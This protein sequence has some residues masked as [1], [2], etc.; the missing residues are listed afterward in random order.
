MIKSIKAVKGADKFPCRWW[1]KV[2]ALKR[3]K[4]IFKPG[5]NVIIGPNGSGK[6]T[7]TK[8]LAKVFFVEQGGKTTFTQTAFMSMYN[9]V[10]GGGMTYDGDSVTV[11]HDGGAVFYMNSADTVGMDG[12]GFDDD[13]FNEG[14]SANCDKVSAGQTSIRSFM[15]MCDIIKDYRD[16]NT[17]AIDDRI[18]GKCNDLYQGHVDDALKFLK[19]NKESV[20][21]LILDEPDASVD[22]CDEI[23]L[24]KI[25]RD[26]STQMQV[27][28]CTHS[29]FALESKANFIEMKKG[30][31]K[32]C[33]ENLEELREN[34]GD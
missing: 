15:R 22:L 3:R 27:I 20:P 9:I 28:V 25:I 33:L 31:R 16:N 6:S 7:L 5:L 19:Y 13:F 2:K 12:G 4:F 11:E 17:E 21:T 29:V 34:K 30:Y 1:D 26:I 14:L 8:T 32:K 24:W 18:G 23:F 10:Y